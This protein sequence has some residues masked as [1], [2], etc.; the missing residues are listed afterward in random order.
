ME[1]RDSFIFYRS[2]FES[3]VELPTEMRVQVYDA[4]CS[5]ALNGEETEMDGIPKAVF[6]LMKPQIEANNK[7]YANGKKPKAEQVKSKQE[8]N[9]KQNRS[10][11]EANNKQNISNNGSKVKQTTSETEAKSKQVKS[12]VEANENEECRMKNV[13]ENDNDEEEIKKEEKQDA[14]PPSSPTS[15]IE[16]F[17]SEFGR[18]LS[19]IE[20]QMICEW[21]KE[22]SNDI[23]M[24]AL[25]E[26]VK[27]NVRNFRYI[28]VIL[29]T[30]KGANVRTVEEAK[31]QIE[32]RKSKSSNAHAQP[33]N[34][35]LPEWFT[36]QDVVNQDTS[37][38]DEE[39]MLKDLEELRH[40]GG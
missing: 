8:A 29:N 36:N 26:G 17:E 35:Q 38:F 40:A 6:I 25:A 39:D 23:V 19:Q 28:E 9:S 30:W 21:Q 33:N 7:R 14:A 5:L 16:S 32:S 27:N 2:F 24:L 1:R 4:I 15:L 34:K 12:K 10:K 22:F 18:T 13:N 11:S 20:V 31:H 3:L 37:D